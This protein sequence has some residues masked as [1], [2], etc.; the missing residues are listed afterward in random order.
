MI[1]AEMVDYLTRCQLD[2]SAPRPSIETLLH[3]FIPA[4]HVHH[5]HPD[6]INALAGAR[7]GELLVAECFGGTAAWVPYVRPGFDLARQV[8]GLVRAN[9]ACV[10]SYS[11]STASLR[12]ET[13]P[14]RATGPRSRSPIALPSSSTRTGPG[15]RS[16]VPR[17]APGASRRPT[18]RRCSARSFRRPRGGLER[19]LEDL[20]VGRIRGGS[21]FLDSQDAR[22]SPRP[23]P[24]AR[25][26]SCTP[27]GFPC[28]CR[29][30]RRSTTR[31]RCRPGFASSRTSS[32]PTTKLLRRAT[33]QTATNRPTR[34]RASW[35]SSI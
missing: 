22:R 23:A 20:W 35:R 4:A 12:G 6:A 7:D 26:T 2:P 33:P 24:P 14:R 17:R 18:A 29:S 16:E 31:P 25:I 15:T 3:A 13:A 21:E 8:G 28:G 5:T 34:T 11:P 27:S 30:I 10:S 1:D 19:A 9:R 32:A